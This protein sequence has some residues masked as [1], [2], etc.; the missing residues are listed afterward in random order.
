MILDV[1]LLN[2]NDKLEKYLSYTSYFRKIYEQIK[3]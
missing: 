2:M 3:K 1:F